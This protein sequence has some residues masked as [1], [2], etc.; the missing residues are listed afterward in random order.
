LI[1]VLRGAKTAKV[2]ERNHD[3]L[4]HFGAGA[5]QSKPYWQGFIRQAVA[6][7]FMYI[8][9]EN[10]GRLRLTKRA[11]HVLAGAERFSM[12]EETEADIKA[13]KPGKKP[14][15]ELNA[16]DN[17]LFAELKNLR[18]QLAKERNVPAYVIFPD[19]TLSEMAAHRPSSLNALATI[20][21]VGP[22]KLD[23][24]G[25]VFLQVISAARA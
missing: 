7:G 4:P 16:E 1:D 22:K 25:A 18:R 10:Y 9:I 2:E 21:G 5:H 23:Q 13:A 15:R 14:L 24:Y 6:G 12:R 19:A 17:D 8:D 11:E 20:N 3:A